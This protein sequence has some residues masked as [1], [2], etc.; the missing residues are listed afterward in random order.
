MTFQT[1][2]LQLPEA[3]YK[4]ARRTAKV[5]KRPVEEVLLNVL[6][7]SLPTLEGLPP[8]MAREL[9]ELEQLTDKKL[10]SVARSTLPE[11]R[12]Q[13][14]SRLLQKNQAGTLTKREHRTLDALVS[15][16]EIL[17]LRKAR[18]FVLLKWRGY[19]PATVIEREKPC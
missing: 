1:V 13:R 3:I 16:S 8:D 7:S 9:T 14:L 12:Q 6:K 18:A 17:M 19:A 11:T 2:T 15:T 4:S 5:V 10:W